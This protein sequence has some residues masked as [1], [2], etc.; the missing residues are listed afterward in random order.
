MSDTVYSFHDDEGYA[1]DSIYHQGHVV[2]HLLT[3]DKELFY[4]EYSA[5]HEPRYTVI[6]IGHQA[7]YGTGTVLILTGTKPVSCRINASKF[8]RTTQCI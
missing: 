2:T 5:R 7:S 4:S 3:A 8:H 6:P 1:E